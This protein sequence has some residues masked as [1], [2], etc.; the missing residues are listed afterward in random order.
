MS[1]AI[2]E[3]VEQTVEIDPHNLEINKNRLNIMESIADSLE[4]EESSEL[5]EQEEEES[6]QET[7]QVEEAPE[8]P[9]EEKPET[10]KIKV[11][12]KEQE[13]EKDKIYEAGIRTLQKETAADKRLEEATA[14]SK[15]AD[16][17]L[18]Q[19]QE[20]IT[21]LPQ[22]AAES[23]AQQSTDVELLDKIRYG[24]E[25]EAKTAM[26]ELLTRQK[27]TYE[28]KTNQVEQR[29]QHIENQQ[30]QAVLTRLQSEYEDIFSNDILYGAAKHQ[31]DELLLKGNPNTYDTYK[32]AL[33]T[34]RETVKG[35][36]KTDPNLAEKTEK[37]RKIVP[38]AGTQAKLPAE[39]EETTE[40]IIMQMKKKRGQI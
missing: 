8:E 13:V 15:K 2:R 10:V 21:Q 30:L 22:G 9:E 32:Q 34:V 17:L 25:A 18:S 3:D 36:T 24:D 12:G 33:D 7:E 14:K 37:K 38:A 16:E 6:G 27:A 11:D 31:V 19:L 29:V 28:E 1:E 26:E 20:K 5:Q 4:E 23:E 35:F 40:D 39:K